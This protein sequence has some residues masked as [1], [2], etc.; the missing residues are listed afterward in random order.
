MKKLNWILREILHRVYERNEYFMSQKSLSQACEVSMETVNRLVAKLHRFRSIEKKP[1]GFRVTGPTKVLTYWASTRNL[2]RD[3]V[4]SAYSPDSASKIERDL[5]PGTIFTAFSGYR[6]GFKEA[7]GPYEEVYAYADPDEVRRRFTE[8]ETERANLFVLR[9]DPHLRRV[10]E[11]GAAPLAQIY[12][13]LWQIGGAKADEFLLEL[14]K[15]LESKSIDVLKT[16][17][18]PPREGDKSE[19]D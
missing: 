10:S 15:R 7:P 16:L 14:E 17:L 19:K 8:R 1:R 12:A 11:G 13:D 6:R 9:S 2:P 5:P 4:Y 18:H 3:I